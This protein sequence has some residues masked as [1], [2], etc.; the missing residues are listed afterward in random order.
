MPALRHQPDPA[1]A[2][3]ERALLTSTAALL[4][5]LSVS[6][7]VL[8]AKAF[9]YAPAGVGSGGALTRI[10]SNLVGVAVM[11]VALELSRVHADHNRSVRGVPARAVGADRG[12]GPGRRAAGR[13]GL[14]RAT[15]GYPAR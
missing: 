4:I 5:L 7:A 15:G 6:A 13:R 9:S 2:D 3:D 14:R 10:G 12:P 1:T 8:V 11:L